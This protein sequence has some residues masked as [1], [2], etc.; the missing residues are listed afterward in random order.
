[1]ESCA[2]GRWCARGPFSRGRSSVESSEVILRCIGL[3]CV[4]YRLPGF[5]GQHWGSFAASGMLA[6]AGI[7]QGCLGSLSRF[8]LLGSRPGLFQMLFLGVSGRPSRGRHLAAG[9]PPRAPGHLEGPPGAVGLVG[10]WGCSQPAA[11]AGSAEGGGSLASALAADSFLRLRLRG[12]GGLFG[13]VH[14][15][16]GFSSS[17]LSPTFWHTWIPRHGVGRATAPIVTFYGRVASPCD[18]C[19]IQPHGIADRCCRSGKL[20]VGGSAADAQLIDQARV[21]PAVPSGS[22][23]ETD[24]P[25]TTPTVSRPYR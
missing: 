14:A 12:A 22:P 15:G 2:A 19:V 23:V 16:C 11:R 9:R 1:M 13:P 10:V 17:M 20:R 4:G 3:V 24:C 8:R 7:R 18:A 5:A 25:R 6:G 21:V